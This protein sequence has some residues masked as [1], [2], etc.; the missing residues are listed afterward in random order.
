M[1]EA[2]GLSLRSGRKIGLTLLMGAA[3]VFLVM[4]GIF[5]LAA[6]AVASLPA[7]GDN[8]VLTQV[9]GPSISSVT[10]L[11]NIGGVLYAGGGGFYGSVITWNGTQG[12]FVGAAGGPVLLPQ[13]T[14]PFTLRPTK[15]R[16]SSPRTVLV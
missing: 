13:S 11:L 16:V 6:P 2:S 4:A 10:A 1:V 5:G 15:S 12:S 3:L 14:V 7:N 8:T 9:G